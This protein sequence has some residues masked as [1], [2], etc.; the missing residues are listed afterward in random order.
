MKKVKW[1]KKQ[2]KLKIKHKW[3][4]NFAWYLK[5]KIIYNNKLM[6]ISV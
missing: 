2:C 1:F 3:L 6:I 4:K 5:T